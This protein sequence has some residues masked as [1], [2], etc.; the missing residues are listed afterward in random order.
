MPPKLTDERTD[1]RT[2]RR[3]PETW[4][5]LKLCD[6]WSAKLKKV[7]GDLVNFKKL[8]DEKQFFVFAGLKLDFLYL[9]TRSNNPKFNAPKPRSLCGEVV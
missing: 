2:D 8:E 6:L 4:L 3:T 5:S 1:G 9:K 7:P